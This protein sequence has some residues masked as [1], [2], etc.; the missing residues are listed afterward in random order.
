M[1]TINAHYLVIAS[2]LLLVVTALGQTEYMWTG[3]A[4]TD[5]FSTAE[6]WTPAGSGF[7]HDEAYII[8][9]GSSVTVRGGIYDVAYWQ[10]QSGSTLTVEEG[11]TLRLNL[12]AQALATSSTTPTRMIINGVVDTQHLRYDLNG[13]S[14]TIEILIN[15]SWDTYSANTGLPTGGCSLLME[16]AGTY[17]LC[18][19]VATPFGRLGMTKAAPEATHRIN[20][21]EGGTVTLQ[22]NLTMQADSNNSASIWLSGGTLDLQYYDILY[23]DLDLSNPENGL[24]VKKIGSKITMLGDRVS[25][26]NQWIARGLLK[27]EVG[28]LLVTYHAGPDQTL[29]TTPN[30]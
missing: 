13:T 27:S 19:R 18:H 25:D 29:V 15:G 23:L 1:T 2:A 16:V 22:K 24:L 6:N 17:S 10:V 9:H 12:P 20:V 21:L 14:G 3:D 7:N 8:P 26:M 4:A 5:N 11:S 30:R 28:E